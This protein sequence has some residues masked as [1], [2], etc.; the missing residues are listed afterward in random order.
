MKNDIIKYGVFTILFAFFH[1]IEIKCGIAFLSIP[2]L[3]ALAFSKQ[4]LLVLSPLFILSGIALEFSWW[5]LLFL[6]TP[7]LVLFIT[8]FIHYKVGKKPKSWLFLIYGILSYIPKVVLSVKDLTSGVYQCAGVVLSIPLFYIFLSVL[9]VILAKKL[10]FPLSTFER[11]SFSITMAVLGFG[12]GYLNIYFFSLYEFTVLLSLLIIPLTG[13]NNLLWASVSFGIG[14]LFHSVTLFVFS[15][16]YGV[17]IA[18][19]KKEYAYFGGIGAVVV[20]S[21]AILTGAVE[22]SYLSLIALSVPTLATIL[23]PNKIKS[24][25]ISKFSLENGGV[26]RALINKNRALVKDKI[27]RLSSCF[28]EVGTS[29]KSDERKESLN[30]L[31]LAN[32]VVNAVCKRC[33]NFQ[34]CKKCLGGNGTEMVIQE[35]MSSAIEIGKASILDAS[36]FLSSRC[37]RLNGLIV[38]AN[39]IL[40]QEQERI[41]KEREQGKNKNLLREQ[42]EGLGEILSLLAKEV[43]TPIVYDLQREKKLRDAFNE[44]GITLKDV[45]IYESGE[46][47]IDLNE[48]DGKKGIV[49]E[50]VSKTMGTPMK[51]VEEKKGVD[52]RVSI[53]FKRDAK[54]RVAYGERVLSATDSGSGDKDAVVRL[55]ESKVML[56][57]SDGMGHG[58]EADENSTC[59]IN[60]IKSF[61]KAGFDHLT[62][63]KSVHTLQKT[64]GKEEFNAV[65]VAVIDTFT[66]EVDFIKQGAREGYIITPDGLEEIPCGSLPLG[67]V[68]EIV[69]VTE[70][71]QLTPRDFLVLVSDGIIDGLGKERLEEILSKTNTRNPDEICAQVMENVVNLVGEDRDDC[72]IIVAR[73]F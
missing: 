1:F 68:D 32:E 54:Y 40:F 19:F 11:I 21:L 41:K 61:Y 7:V 72:S 27:E 57:L 12:L 60:L 26:T 43:G 47:C 33:G 51:G 8:F 34:H 66:G 4:N 28:Y 59:A 9:F 6:A 14:G 42:V 35:L 62:V 44:A 49:R 2:F 38:K 31:D 65:D 71:R 5:K 15:I 13:K 67:I 64:R 50:I 39:E 46:I 17:L 55:S 29:L 37:V 25:I 53:T 45:V 24:K 73:L 69:P 48:Y 63:L 3:F 58:K 36:P 10:N 18:I 70:V 56:C 16:V 20:K 30:P 22:S 52:G 23:L